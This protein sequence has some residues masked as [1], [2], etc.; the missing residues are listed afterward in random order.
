MKKTIYPYSTL[1]G[2]LELLLSDVRIDGELVGT[3]SVSA[4]DR[5]LTL[6]G[7]ET[8]YWDHLSFRVNVQVPPSALRLFEDE[9]GLLSLTIVASCRPTNFRQG[10]RLNRSLQDPA[11]WSGMADLSRA[12]F[13]DKAM[14]Q[15]ILTGTVN[16]ARCR[17]VA[18]S[19]QW[20]LY[21]DP[22]ESFRTAGSLAVR[23]CDFKA[24]SAPPIA[25]QFPD[26]PY[27]VE[28]DKALPEILLNTSFEGLEPLL[29]D[30]KDR[31]PAEQ[32]LHDSTRMSMARSV[33]MALLFDSM[34]AIK[35]GE[36]NEDPTWPEREW[37]AEVLK[38]MLPEIDSVKSEPEILRLAARE[39]RTHPG[40]GAF[41]SRAEA[42]I[43]EFVGA[44]KSLRKSTQ[45][46]LRKGIV[47]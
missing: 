20:T 18:V 13:R 21:F 25:K 6:H 10:I 46:L 28:M 33:W 41:L 35:P 29:R 1:N 24:E 31:S 30:T 44:N 5:L 14:L 26:A 47:S 19:D 38:R 8:K 39:W 27:V 9:H 3:D 43:G 36:D 15:A 22:S 42:A 32:A 12:S 7:L 45:T 16:S 4:N 34:A 11:H 2:E 37:Q 23:W 40:S 17:P